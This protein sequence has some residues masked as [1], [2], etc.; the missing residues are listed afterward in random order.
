MD[1]Q[2]VKTASVTEEKG[3]GREQE[4]KWQKAIYAD[5]HAGVD[6][7]HFDCGGK[8]RLTDGSGK[9]FQSSAGE[10]SE[11]AESVSRSRV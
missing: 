11:I 10:I 9:T 5:R 4:N 6:D 7:G 8:C 1:S 3:S 2:S